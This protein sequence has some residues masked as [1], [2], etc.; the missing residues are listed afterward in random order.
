MTNYEKIKNMTI[1]EIA[2]IFC[3]IDFDAFV[4]SAIIAN[5]KNGEKRKGK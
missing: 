5:C 2:E 4:R 3:A 1:E